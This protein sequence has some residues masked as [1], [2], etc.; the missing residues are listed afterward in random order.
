VISNAPLSHIFK[1]RAELAGKEE[2]KRKQNKNSCE[3]PSASSLVI[4]IMES[5]LSVM[6]V[7]HR[8]P[9]CPHPVMIDKR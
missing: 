5:R 7:M 9:I 1:N 2:K 3:T 4:N 6:N 8:D